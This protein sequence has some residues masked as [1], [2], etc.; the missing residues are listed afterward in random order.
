MTEGRRPSISGGVKVAAGRRVQVCCDACYRMSPSM[1]GTPDQVLAHFR[2]LGWTWRADGR[3]LCPICDAR[4]PT[5][6]PPLHDE[7]PLDG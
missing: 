5:T 1:D 6:P 2:R 3:N 4:L 7:L